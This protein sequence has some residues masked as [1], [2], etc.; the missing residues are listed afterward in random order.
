[1]E[2]LSAENMMI[3]LLAGFSGLVLFKRAITHVQV[4]AKK[5]RSFER[6]WNGLE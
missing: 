2:H 1:M 6:K 4:M 3:F 5:P